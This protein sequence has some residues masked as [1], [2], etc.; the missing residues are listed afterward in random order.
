VT[1]SPDLVKVNF[2]INDMYSGIRF[3]EGIPLEGLILPGLHHLNELAYKIIAEEL[4][5]FF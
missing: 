4:M 1:F 3:G 5:R 2:G